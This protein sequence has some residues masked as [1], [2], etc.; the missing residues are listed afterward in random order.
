[1]LYQAK[2]P[3][4]LK[5]IGALLALARAQVSSIFATYQDYQSISELRDA[6][7]EE[8]GLRRRPDGSIA[9]FHDE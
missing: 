6:E 9:T 8:L 2:R 4:V 3:S 7:L 1:M 5:R